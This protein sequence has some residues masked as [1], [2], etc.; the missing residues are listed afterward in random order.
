MDGGINRIERTGPQPA[1]RVR[2]VE[3]EPFTLDDVVQR[4]EREA[5]ERDADAEQPD[6]HDERPI[7]PRGDD[8]NGAR[9]DLTA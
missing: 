6:E 1:A 9:I 5:D 8:E 7:A 4:E 2:R 3:R